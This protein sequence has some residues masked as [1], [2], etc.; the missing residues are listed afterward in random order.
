MN[1]V[2]LVFGDNLDNYQQVYFSIYTAFLHKTPEDKIIVITENTTLFESFGNK[3][4]VIS[5]D[6]CN[7]EEWEGKH[8][9]FWRV[10]IKALELVAQKYP[11]ESIL[12]LDGDTFFFE[13][14]AVLKEG[15]LKGQNYM[16]VNEGK[17]SILPTK[18]EKLMWNQ[19][20]KKSYRGIK[21][22]ENT[23]MWNAGLIGISN[24]HLQCLKLTLDVN[25][26]LCADNVTRRLI[27]QFSFSIS[28]NEYS[29][30]LP[31]TNVIG[32][33]WGNKD[34][35]NF[36]ISSFLKECFMKQYS[37]EQIMNK[38]QQ[39]DL[40]QYPVWVRRSNTQRRLKRIIDSFYKDLRPKY[41][42]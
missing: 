38:I 41:V 40:K 24:K 3:I 30:L 20:K 36:I 28:L 1:I 27:E 32:H 29:K 42:K 14:I 33:Y 26:E 11:T 9:F 19:I 16:H 8:K 31:G 21:I 15:L 2:Y 12:Y 34:Q 10:K 35:W 23:C 39:I 17:L 4:E 37:F 22:D 7:I 25:D 6:R 5:I 13:N 18:T